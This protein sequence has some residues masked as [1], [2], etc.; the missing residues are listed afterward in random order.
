VD[1]TSQQSPRRVEKVECVTRGGSVDDD[2]IEVAVLVQLVQL[3]HCH[4][5]LRTAER[6]RHVSVEA[7]VEYASRLVFGF[8]VPGYELIEGRLRVEHQRGDAAAGSC[9]STDAVQHDRVHTQD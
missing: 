5:F 2:E 6:A 9:G 4:V 7:V 1:I 8:R 3:L